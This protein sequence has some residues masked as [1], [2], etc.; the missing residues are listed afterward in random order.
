MAPGSAVRGKVTLEANYFYF[1]LMMKSVLEYLL[2]GVISCCD[3]P[4]RAA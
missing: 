2:E 3:I 4:N 1:V